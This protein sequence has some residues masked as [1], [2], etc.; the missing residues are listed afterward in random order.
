MDLSLPVKNSKKIINAWCSY[1]IANSAYSLSISTVLYPIY[2][3]E[4][5]NKAWG[6][7]LVQFAGHHIQNTVLYDYAI[8]CGY[9]LIII[10]T[11][12]LSGVADLGGYRKR[13]MQI[14]TL[15][16]ALSCMA[17]YNFNGHNL[18]LGIFFPALAVVG[19]AGSLVYYNSFLPIIATSDQFDRV[20]AKGFSW[21]YAGSM[22]LLI[23]NLYSIENYQVFG[24]AGKME[25]VRFAFLEVG[26]WWLGISQFAFR[27]LK[28]YKGSFTLKT[29]VFGKGFH[30]IIQV[31]KAIQKQNQMRIFL[32]AFLLFSVGVQTIILVATLFGSKELGIT[33]TKLIITILLIQVLAIVGATIFGKVSS[34]FGNKISLTIML[35]IWTIVCGIAY[36]IRSDIHFFFL[37]SMVGL[38]MGGIQS[39][40]RSTYSKMIPEDSM[41]TSSYFSFYDIT[42]KAAIVIGMFSFGFLEQF[43]GSMRNSALFLGFLFLISLI[44]VLF[45]KLPKGTA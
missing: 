8:A 24:F 42:E 11:P 20:S 32:L 30:E 22:I 41:D 29:H 4:V 7:S 31:F 33:G 21:G 17:L 37:A 36:F 45:S 44:L 15:L 19:Y 14:F 26:I 3:Q 34:R 5:T 35:C 12:L 16:G 10:L 13:F 27:H 39:Q 28:E 23:F 2:Y 6:S 38:V 40:A 1:D 18:F 25:A 9:L 43:T